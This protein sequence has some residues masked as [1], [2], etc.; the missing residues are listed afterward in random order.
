[1]EIP[2]FGGEAQLRVRTALKA[3]GHNMD[4]LGIALHMTVERSRESAAQEGLDDSWRAS[5]GGVSDV[6]ADRTL[7]GRNHLPSSGGSR[8]RAM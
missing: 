3:P 6:A 1:M 5:Y 2:A 4:D 8:H 7:E